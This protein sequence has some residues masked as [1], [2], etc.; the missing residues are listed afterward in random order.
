LIS[1]AAVTALRDRAKRMM[2]DVASELVEQ[3]DGKTRIVPALWPSPDF[4]DFGIRGDGSEFAGMR[5][6]E[7]ETFSGKIDL[8]AKFVDV[9]A[10]ST[11]ARMRQDDRIVVMGEDVHRLKGGTNGATRG[12]ATEFPDRTLGTPISECA[13]SGL[14]GG[15]AMDGRYIPIV[16]FMYP[17]FLWVAADQLFNQI[18]KA[19]HMFGGEGEMPLVLRT[20]VAIGTGYGSQHSM[21]PAGIFATSVGWRIVA[22][23]TPFDY[24]GLM[25]SALR[26]KDP[27]VVI[28]HVDLYNSKGPAPIDDFDYFVPLG[29]AKVL[30][31]GSAMTVLTYLGMVKPVLERVAALGVDAEVIDLRSLDRAGL[32]WEI[33]E[34][35]I[36]KTNNVLIVEQ[37]T[38]GPS[39]GGFLADEIQSRLFDH[40]D[41]PI[42]RVLGGE[43]SP[44]ISKVLEAAAAAGL[45]DIDRGLLR[46]M[47]E[48]GRPLNRG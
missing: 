39:Y 11:L 29:R 10:D 47:A 13:F 27:V 4:R 24:V 46:V 15:I 16:E 7:L 8:D 26:S 36:R 45:A 1:E 32:D 42:Q 5:Y 48:Q 33:I 38:L 19:R 25:N 23:S 21:D 3:A 28:E 44:S 41:Q 34:A 9:I 20:K 18:A 31:S 6:E 14:A 17:D 37:G 30:R 35:S 40:L 43:A 12:M 2:D 22:P